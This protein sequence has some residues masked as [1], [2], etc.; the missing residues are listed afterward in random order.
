MWGGIPLPTCVSSNFRRTG[1]QMGV[2]CFSLNT[3]HSFLLAKNNNI[4]YPI[5]E[6]VGKSHLLK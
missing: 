2:H 1:L 5:W 4:N 6:W 3:Q